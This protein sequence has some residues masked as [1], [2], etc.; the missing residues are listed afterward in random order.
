MSHLERINNKAVGAA[1]DHVLQYRVNFECM[2][3]V[4]NYISWWEYVT[5]ATCR[6]SLVISLMLLSKV[7]KNVCTQGG[8]G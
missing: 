8:H 7:Q 3:I 4:L 6:L 1:C 5:S 2:F